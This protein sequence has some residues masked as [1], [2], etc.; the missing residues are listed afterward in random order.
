MEAIITLDEQNIAGEHICCAISD[1]KC[2]E[3]YEAKKEW[4]RSQLKEGYVFKKLDVRGKVFIEYVPAEKAWSPVDA[5]DHLMINCFWVSGQYKGKGNAKRLL[6]EAI[7]DAK[8]KSGLVAITSAKKQPFLSDR[9]FFQMQGFQKCDEAAPYFELWYL[10]LKKDAT[11]PRFKEVARKGECD[12][13]EGLAVYYSHGCPFTEHYVKVLEE[14]ATSKGFKIQTVKISN[15]EQAQSHFVPY[16][17]HSV[18]RDGKF[19]T[20]HILNEKYFDKFFT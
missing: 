3:G 10:P 11:V 16:T 15:R 1:K 18:F 19:V 4:I 17:N 20:Q 14:V 13:T 2:R 5:P 9:K 8:G 6:Q 12:I 7:H